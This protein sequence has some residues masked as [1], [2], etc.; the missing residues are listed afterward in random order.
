M[1]GLDTNALIRLVVADD[2]AQFTAIQKR[3]QSVDALAES[4]ALNDVVLVEALWTLR[5]VYGFE[6]ADL[7]A[8]LAKL[9]AT[10]T[11]K[12]E[13]REVLKQATGWYS[14]TPADFADCLIAAKYAELGCETTVT[15]DRGMKALPMVEVLTAY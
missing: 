3:L 2:P 11:F 13:N 8:L 14:T 15:F 6:R 4:V 7:Q 12:F 1:I 10:H 9:L 5:R